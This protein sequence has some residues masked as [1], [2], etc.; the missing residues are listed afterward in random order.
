ML[1]YTKTGH[2]GEAAQSFGD[3]LVQHD[4]FNAKRSRT[5]RNRESKQVDDEIPPDTE[6]EVTDTSVTDVSEE[7]DSENDSVDFEL[8][9]AR[10]LKCLQLAFDECKCATESFR[11][12]AA[13]KTS[14]PKDVSAFKHARHN[15][16]SSIDDC[17]IQ[18]KVMERK[19]HEL[20]AM[21]ADSFP[22]GHPLA[23]KDLKL[24][25]KIAKCFE[26]DK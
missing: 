19:L 22:A 3:S 13:A 25:T 20:Q 15:F 8:A 7:E 26:Q 17:T 9:Y 2:H 11:E 14:R 21:K 18:V 1:K 6:N 4:T 12:I 10:A 5:E 16:N 24:R 23:H